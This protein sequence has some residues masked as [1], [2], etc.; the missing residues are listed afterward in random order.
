MGVRQSAHR[1]RS[2]RLS[3]AT[4]FLSRTPFG[5]RFMH[6]GWKKT[7]TPADR[8]RS[9]SVSPTSMAVLQ[10]THLCVSLHRPAHT[11]LGWTRRRT[12]PSTMIRSRSRT[13]ASSG[14]LSTPPRIRGR[15]RRNLAIRERSHSHGTCRRDPV[16]KAATPLNG[17]TRATYHGI[18]R[19]D[20]MSADRGIIEVPMLQ[21]DDEASQEELRRELAGQGR[22]VIEV[23]PAP[24]RPVT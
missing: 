12:P 16:Y 7:F 18:W 23:H 15:P 4:P 11:R 3:P 21:W 9:N 13:L 17:T 14:S 2:G 24:T 19:N 6:R 10:A 1:G 8:M 22:K 20:D 5:Q